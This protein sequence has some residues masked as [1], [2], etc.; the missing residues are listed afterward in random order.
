MFAVPP[1]LLWANLTNAQSPLPLPVSQEKNLQTIIVLAA[2][3]CSKDP[4]WMTGL[5]LEISQLIW[6]KNFQNFNFQIWVV[7]GLPWLSHPYSLIGPNG[8]LLKL[9][10]LAA[11]P[12]GNSSLVGSCE[13]V[14]VYI[15]KVSGSA[16]VINRLLGTTQSALFDSKALHGW[17]LSIYFIQTSPV[18][19]D[20]RLGY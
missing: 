3:V 18:L 20:L 16:M 7:S 13:T 12:K 9:I 1:F 11:G 5:V 15:S 14:F 19:Y 4:S 17:H 6:L 8:L 2:L 10:K